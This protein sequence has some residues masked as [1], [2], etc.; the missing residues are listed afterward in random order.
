VTRRTGGTA[1]IDGLKKNGADLVFLVPGESYLEALDAFYDAQESLHPIVCRQ[2]GGAAYMAEAFGKLTGRPGI[3]FVTRGP[4]ATN[5]SIAVHTAKQDST[6]MILFVGQVDSGMRQREAFQEISIEGMFGSLAKWAGEI[7]DAARVPEYVARA[8]A[9]ATSGRPGPVVIGLP[10]DILADETDAQGVAAART[11][12]PVPPERAVRELRDALERSR[13][14][15]AILGGSGW[16]P[17]ARREITAFLESWKL[18]AACGFRRQDRIDNRSASYVG[19]AGVGILPYLAAKIRQADLIIAIGTRLSEAVTQGYELIEVPRPQQKLVHVYPDPDEL[20]R[21]Y[22]AD[23]AINATIPEFAKVLAGLR[24][25]SGPRPAQPPWSAWSAALREECEASQSVTAREVSAREGFV[26]LADV[27]AYLNSALPDDA[28]VTTGAGNFAGWVHRYYRYRG[29]PTA[30]GAVN[31]SM[32]Y[33]LP[34]AIAAKLVD[35]KRAA[36]AFCGD[37]DFLMT[38]QE[39]A[40]AVQYGAAVIVIVANNGMYGTI[41]MHQEREHPERVIGTDLRNPDFTK[42]AEAFGAYGERVATGA[43]FP[44][45]F[46][47]ARAA[48]RPALLEVM[49]DPE[50]LSTRATIQSLRERA[51]AR[52][53]VSR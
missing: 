35:P 28:V 51:L 43:D 48:G 8:F 31:G 13:R 46:E 36:V 21:V 23:V 38:G 44:R 33:G 14:P 10:E 30:L 12:V 32:G 15:L 52:S 19:Y 6:P 25:S 29:Y 17:E 4:G 3:C 2:E 24:P 47:R 39:L 22:Q 18:P 7:N 45:A 41:R 16:T 53:G 11:T 40:T 26:D 49:V 9:V 50:L 1:L 20:G 37:G 42:L 5:A 27:I 34:A